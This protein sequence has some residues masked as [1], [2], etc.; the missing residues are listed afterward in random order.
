MDWKQI[1]RDVTKL[2][3]YLVDT[4]S[5]V[6]LI[7]TLCFEVGQERNNWFG[8]QKNGLFAFNCKSKDIELQ[9]YIRYDLPD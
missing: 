6:R 7:A 4:P 2:K 8:C 5:Q 1:E 9:K 3:Y